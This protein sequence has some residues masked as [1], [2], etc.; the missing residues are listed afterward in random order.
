M[1]ALHLCSQHGEDKLDLFLLLYLSDSLGTVNEVHLVHTYYNAYTA[2]LTII[3]TFIVERN[4]FSLRRNC[5]KS[6]E[7]VSYHFASPPLNIIE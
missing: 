4:A 1:L 5:Y 3:L 6:A 7:I 2:T